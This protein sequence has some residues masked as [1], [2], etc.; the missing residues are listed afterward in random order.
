MTDTGAMWE[1]VSA[2]LEGLDGVRHSDAG[3]G[4]WQVGGR[5]LARRLDDGA[6]LVRCDFGARE[7]LLRDHPE[8]FYVTPDQEAHQKVT[9]DLERGERGAVA[10]ALR[11]AW[12]LQRRP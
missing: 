12:E 2:V 1:H 3:G 10:R 8:T 11:E 9:V 4:R 5:L 6:L 7:Q